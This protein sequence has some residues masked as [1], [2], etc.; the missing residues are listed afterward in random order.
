MLFDKR[1]FPELRIGYNR[2]SMSES[3]AVAAGQPT[4]PA[5]LAE[6]ARDYFR[7]PKPPV[8]SLPM[9]ATGA[10]SAAGV[11]R[12]NETSCRPIRKRLRSTCPT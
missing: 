5:L 9:P 3:M 11:G 2:R 12:R 8:P 10:T 1:R 7:Q 6:R 4:A